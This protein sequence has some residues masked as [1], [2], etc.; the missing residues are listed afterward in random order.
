VHGLLRHAEP[1]GL[2]EGDDAG[3]SAQE[4]L[5][6]HGPEHPGDGSP[7]WSIGEIACFDQ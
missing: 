1:D 6:R 2:A 5:E 4:V 3:L 7:P